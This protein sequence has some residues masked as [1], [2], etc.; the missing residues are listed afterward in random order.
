VT[1]ERSLVIWGT[2]PIPYEIR[3]SARRGTVSLLIDP[4]RGLVVTAPQGTPIPRLDAVVKAK[5]LWVVERL[6][7]ARPAPVAPTK[8]FVSGEGFLYLGRQCRL[9]VTRGAPESLSLHRGWLDL[10]IPDVI[11][12][13]HRQAYTRAGLID[14]YRGLARERLPRWTEAWAARMGMALGRVVVADQAK[15]WGSCSRGVIRLNW[16][17]IQA[18]RPLV[19]YV[20]AHELVHLAHPDHGRA[21]WQT[22]G[23][24]MPDYDGR[25]ARLRELGPSLV[26]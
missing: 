24:V 15:R 21:F 9:R 18:P 11:E 17:I 10:P 12:P 2:T 23:R 16:R 20:I 4:Q 6:Q 19:D 25:K 7:Q 8:E 26:W 5:A 14:W 3:R 13:A 22:L 1:L